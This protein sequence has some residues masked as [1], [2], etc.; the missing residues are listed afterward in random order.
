MEYQK[1]FKALREAFKR[2]RGLISYRGINIIQQHFSSV[3]YHILPG[4]ERY[5]CKQHHVTFHERPTVETRRLSPLELSDTDILENKYFT[6]Y[7]VAPDSQTSYEN[8][9]LL[10]HGL[11]EKS[12]DKY[13]PWAW[14]LANL[15]QRPVILFPIA[16]HM[17]RAPSIW[18]D[19]RLMSEFAKGRQLRHTDSSNLS[20]INTAI[21]FRLATRPDRLFWSGLQTYIDIIALAK[22]INSGRL[23]L[24]KAGTFVDI[25]GYSMGA[26]L[27]II[28]LMADPHGYFSN[29]KLF[30]FCGGATLDRTYTISKYILDS[31]AAVNISSYFSEQLYNGFRS[32]P[33]LEHYMNHHV[34]EGHFKL[35]LNHNYY[36]KERELAIRKI[37]DRIM[38]VPLVRDTVVPPI[39]V[40]NTLQGDYRNIP[41]RVEPMDFGFPYDHEHPFSLVSKYGEEV[42]RAFANLMHKAADFYLNKKQSMPNAIKVT[43]LK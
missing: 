26:F 5:T 24:F 19:T 33:R 42:N 7:I 36:K 18:S 10:L 32:S 22:K 15:M 35:M 40:L 2:D 37:V 6:Y 12:W 17:E 28:L 20:F 34:K 31:N 14:Q 38:A 25:F 29:A 16:F 43:S 23:P 8:A 13:L 4:K 3:G 9:I 21:S 41:T 1:L 30:S 39:E 11:N 27:S